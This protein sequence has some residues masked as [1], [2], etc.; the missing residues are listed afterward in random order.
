M[1]AKRKSMK[2][3][4]R[5]P[6][7]ILIL[8]LLPNI[9]PAQ[10]GTDLTAN[11]Q[12]ITPVIDSGSG[13]MVNGFKHHDEQLALK[14]PKALFTLIIDG[15]KYEASDATEISQNTTGFSFNLINKLECNFEFDDDFHL[16][17][18]AVFS[19]TNTS[20][21]TLI[22]ENFVPFGES[23]DHLHI[24]STGPWNL[25]RSKIFRPG[26]GPI[27]VI[28]PDNAWELGYASLQVNDE[29]SV[30]ALARR[31]GWE[32]SKRRR[33]KTEVY[34]GGEIIW[35]IRME[36]FTGDWQ[37]GI[38]KA[39]QERWL[40]DL[41]GFDNTLFEREDLQWIKHDYL[42]A[43]QMAWDH[44]FYDARENEYTVKE[45]L[46][47]G[48]ELMG[49]YDVYSIWPTWPRL[50][51]DQRNQWDMYADLPG[52]LPKI[53]E[54]SNYCQ[55]RGTKFFIA[56]NPWD[57]STRRENPYKGMARL[58]D[59]TY[60]DGVVL[61]TRGASSYEL[62]HAADSVRPGVVM[63]SEGM[64]IPKDMP[65]IVSGRVHDAIFMPPPLNMNKLIKPDFGIF[66]VCQL[67]QGRIRRE[68]NISLFNG[69]GIELNTYY[70]GRPDWVEEEFLYLG[71]IVK[72]LREN[73]V[74]FN[75][76]D[77]TPLLPA[78]TDS[79]WVNHF[80]SENKDIYTIYSLIPEGF[81]GPLFEAEIPENHHL[82]SLWHHEE[83]SVDTIDGKTY[84]MVNTRAFYETWTGTRRESAV[85]VI[86][87]LPKLLSAE[88][89]IDSLFMAATGGDKIVI[90]AGNPTYQTEKINLAAGKHALK[91]YD[92][93]EGYEGKIVVQLFDE[94]NQL[95]DERIT[96]I[97][98]A[99]PRLISETEQ[100]IPA[101]TAPEGMLEIPAGT[102]VF[103]ASNRD[104]FIPYPK[105]SDGDTLR[106]E[107]YY[108]DEFPVTNADYARF[109]DESGYA[110]ENPKNFLKHWQDKDFPDSLARRPVVN[111]TPEDASAYCR[112]YG[113]RLP[114]EAEWQYAAQGADGRQWP[115]GNE[116]DSTLCNHA[117]GISTPV[118]RFLQGASP[119]GIKD[120]T[121]NVCQ[122]TDD[123]YDNGSYFYTILKG[124]SFYKPTSSWWYVQGGPQPATHQQMLLRVSP[125]LD[126]NATVG[127]RCVRDRE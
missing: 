59:A 37:N 5:K 76:Y 93:F 124:G 71:K 52:G 23:A 123:D 61:D 54:I 89:R 109:L 88:R 34:P 53:R 14:N 63:Y 97:P 6:A 40:Y 30:Y 25:A 22:I 43:L 60:A 51:L 86:A 74:N 83:V 17:W 21:D 103:S 18:K 28:L 45:F 99:L 120:M 126:R 111:I 16:G 47:R 27:G 4:T 69:Y 8:M 57:Q 125:S 48:E 101:G 46:A 110:P 113:K 77:W 100:T 41:E 50:G 107:K 79:I 119:F 116:F 104:Q 96:G 115:W 81:S 3:T 122:I 72:V 42:I 73:S 105:N 15:T 65:G 62:Q 98:L 118:D 10:A 82:V 38:R 114:T 32:G 106:M 35:T 84:P 33:Y 92:H 13:I 67:S 20:A 19:A 87:V 2:H 95:L 29:I 127:F 9:L 49:G 64:A 56:Y 44:A 78:A 12:K 68:A 24:T 39:F 70:P 80:P 112:F 31:T 91:L 117:S 55:S 66:R 121:G 58:I 108:M 26:R 36:S 85:D 75:S 90:S 1:N 7:I 102:F 11:S 94:N